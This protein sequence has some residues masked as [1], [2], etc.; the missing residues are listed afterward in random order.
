MSSF[1][2]ETY[3]FARHKHDANSP[4]EPDIER[5]DSFRINMACIEP[6][7]VAHHHLTG[8]QSY[9]QPS[10]PTAH[11]LVIPFHCVP[12]FGIVVCLSERDCTKGEP[13]E[14]TDDWEGVHWWDQ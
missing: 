8:D 12:R 9:S 7:L 1:K 5:C 10:E 4:W 14:K 6:I 3:P 11:I 13:E 2:P